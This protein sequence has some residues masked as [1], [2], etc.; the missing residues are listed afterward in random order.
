MLTKNSK[1]PRPGEPSDDALAQDAQAVWGAVDQA[2]AD[3]QVAMPLPI[4]QIMPDAIQPRRVVP[5]AVFTSLAGASTPRDILIEW[6][7]LAYY[8]SSGVDPD[9]DGPNEAFDFYAAVLAGEQPVNFPEAPVEARLLELMTLAMD[10]VDVGLTNAITVAASHGLDLYHIE[11]GERRWWAFQLLTLFEYEGYDR[12]PAR[13]VEYDIWRQASENNQRKDLNAV[14]KARQYALLLMDL[15]RQEGQE[16]APLSTFEHEQAFYAQ[17]ADQTVPYGGTGALLNAMG[18]NSRQS[19][20]NYTHLLRIPPYVWA[21]ADDENW[22][23]RDLLKIP[24][25]VQPL[26]SLNMRSTENEADI[27]D[28]SQ[29]E[30]ESAP[31]PQNGSLEI[32][33]AVADP[34]ED[35]EP[36]PGHPDGEIEGFTESPTTA[37]SEGAPS[38]PAPAPAATQQ[39]WPK[40]GDLVRTSAG[41]KG[42]VTTIVSA[43]VVR[44]KTDF[45]ERL[46]Q[47]SRELER[48]TEPVVAY[49]EDPGFNEWLQGDA[50]TEAETIALQNFLQ[51][52]HAHFFWKLGK[53]DHGSVSILDA[54]GVVVARLPVNSD[55]QRT[56]YNQV[57][58]DAL[59][60]IANSFYASEH[61]QRFYRVLDYLEM[62]DPDVAPADILED[63]DA[64]REMLDEAAADVQSEMDQ[65]GA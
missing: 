53:G 61:L 42:T 6:L 11:T 10:I 18:L 4:D 43:D 56:G 22:T 31:G 62:R 50:S 49:E 35:P 39:R 65:G 23:L 59:I 44:V 19:L 51:N 45:S 29:N 64:L 21:Q 37:R 12:I 25:T 9:D 2:D 33:V 55:Y 5:H 17:V 57:A 27:P 1:G 41:H 54:T 52:E 40:V 46:Y 16:F 20:S 30:P 26:D 47:V 7:R 8:E 58:A 15:L 14:A 3:M 28:I 32:R 34:D 13:I 63:I 36:Q 38:P 48:W 24:Q 60:E